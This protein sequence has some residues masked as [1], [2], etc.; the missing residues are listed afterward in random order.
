MLDKNLIR[1]KPEIVKKD[2]TKRYQQ[3]KIK[4]IDNLIT[5]DKEW[6][7][8]KKQV[9]TLRHQRN[10]LTERI[11]KLKQENKPANREINEAKS[12]PDKVKEIEERQQILEKEI[13]NYLLRIPNISHKSVPKG[14]DSKDNK[15]V[16]KWG[17][18]K[19]FNFNL[20]SHGELIEKFKLG[21]FDNA[22]RISGHGFN[23][24]F[25]KLVLLDLA[26]IRFAI[27]NITKKGFTLVEPPLML[28]RKPYEGVTDLEDFETMM[29]KIENEDLYLIAT[30][31]HA[32]ATMFMDKT[33][34]IEDLPLK[35]LGIS[36]CFRK[37]IGSHGVDQKGLFRVHQ[38]NKV[39][40][41]IFSNS[42][43]SWK[44]HEELIKNAE[45][46]FKK[47]NLPYRIVNICSGDLGTVASKKYDLEI[48]SPRQKEYIEA[49]SCS[50]CT[51]Y[52]ARRLNIKYIEKNERDY[53]HTLN[54][55]AIATGRAIVGILE[56]F[57][58]KD[59]SIKIP[60]VLH[61]YLNFKKLP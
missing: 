49:V 6:R 45:D 50:N 56:N 51:D 25:S 41:F 4:W 43:D 14:K 8:L 54:S 33:I 3:D 40:Q 58:Q 19:K 17:K 1:E 31:E 21:D 9:D 27:D 7:L 48:W 39:E 36:P 61:K 44:I 13:K 18:I 47:L 46:L 30:S 34:N 23:F 57:Q 12:I 29:Y 32:I 26:L 20:K 55:T 52:Q 10:I 15:V 2:L 16:R 11:R 24:L 28:R 22:A 37:E 60:T 53:V 5:K 38:F 35:Y 59:C 42:K